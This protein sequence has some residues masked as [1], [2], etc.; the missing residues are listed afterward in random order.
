M[1]PGDPVR[2]FDVRKT[3]KVL[4]Y[5]DVLPG[6]VT[7]ACWGGRYLAREV[8]TGRAATH[9]QDGTAYPLCRACWPDGMPE[10]SLST[11]HVCTGCPVARHT[12]PEKCEHYRDNAPGEPVCGMPSGEEHGS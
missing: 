1:S 4:K 10:S 3:C 11:E 7:I 6:L 8:H 9:R 2:T 12:Q 5:D